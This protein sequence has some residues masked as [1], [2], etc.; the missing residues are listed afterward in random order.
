MKGAVAG[1]QSQ[2]RSDRLLIVG[3]HLKEFMDQ[4]QNPKN[5]GEYEKNLR[6]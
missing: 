3:T 1:I 4:E 6:I 5:T 2:S